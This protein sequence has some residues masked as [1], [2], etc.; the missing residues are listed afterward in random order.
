MSRLKPEVLS[1]R[2]RQ[3]LA[4]NQA[5]AVA[6]AESFG[7][8]EVQR[9]RRQ[10]LVQDATEFDRE[11]EIHHRMGTPETAQDLGKFRD[12][13]ILRRTEAQASP[14]RTVREISG[15][16]LVGVQDAARETQ[17]D[18]ALGGELH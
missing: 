18:L 16:P 17:H 6:L 14:H 11:F 4:P 9:P 15:G 13:Q 2:P 5:P 3:R 1:S 10:L 7:Q 12:D 8:H